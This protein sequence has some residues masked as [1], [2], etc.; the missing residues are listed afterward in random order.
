MQKVR[1][2][3]YSLRLLVSIQFQVLFH[4]LIQGS[5]HLSLTVL[6]S[7]SLKKYLGL[8]N[9]LPMFKQDFTC[10]V[11]LDQKLNIYL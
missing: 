2:Q 1:R 11:L 8:E 4:S 10:P 7:I 6:S 5:F 9:G 3:D